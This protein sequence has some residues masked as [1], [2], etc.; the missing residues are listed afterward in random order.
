LQLEDFSTNR[1]GRVFVSPE[2]LFL[3]RKSQNEKVLVLGR[4]SEDDFNC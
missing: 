1:N 3:E 4:L 2:G